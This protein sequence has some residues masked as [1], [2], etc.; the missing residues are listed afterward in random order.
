M[1]RMLDIVFKGMATSEAIEARVRK[2]AAKLERFRDRL[3]GCRVVIEAPH[4]RHEKGNL[5]DIRI[6]LSL[7]GRPPIVVSRTTGADH[8]HEDPY[9]ALRDAFDAAKRQL[10]DKT[11]RQRGDVKNHNGPTKGRI[12]RL[13]ADEGYGFIERDD[14]VEV[15]F[16]QNSVLDPGFSRLKVGD[17]VRFSEEDG[18]QGPQA[19]TVHPP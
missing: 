18:E 16:H 17:E 9:V 1:Q 15:Y 11:N 5:F 7:P 6:E 14:G 4:R 19:S 12:V 13:L 2:E 8:S 10:Q 3:I